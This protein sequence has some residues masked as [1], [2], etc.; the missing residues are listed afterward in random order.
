MKYKNMNLY[1]AAN[2]VIMN[3]LDQMGA[4]GG[5]IAV[6]RNGQFSMTFN[7]AGMYRGYV[8]SDGKKETLIYSDN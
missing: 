6:D 2:E 5:I 1:Q 3:K 4:A 8:T 7:T